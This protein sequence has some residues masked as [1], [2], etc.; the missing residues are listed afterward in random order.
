MAQQPH[1]PALL[2]GWLTPVYDFF[3]RRFIPDLTLAS[4][5]LHFPKFP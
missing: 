5:V 2:V 3:A 4:R 1:Y